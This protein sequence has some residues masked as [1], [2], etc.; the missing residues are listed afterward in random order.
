[1]STRLFNR[2]DKLSSTGVAIKQV[3]SHQVNIYIGVD[4][5]LN[6]VEELDHNVVSGRINAKSLDRGGF[7]DSRLNEH[8]V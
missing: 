7:E 8:S 6:I 3:I 2:V 5:V 1:M 4:V